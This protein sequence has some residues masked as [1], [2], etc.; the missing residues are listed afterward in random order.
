MKKSDR[1]NQNMIS[2]EGIRIGKAVRRKD[3][4]YFLVVKK[5][6]KDIYTEIPV[7]QLMR[8]IMDA[9]DRAV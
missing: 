9:A 8:D 3:G 5:P 2:Y 1:D 6:G 7:M 4:S